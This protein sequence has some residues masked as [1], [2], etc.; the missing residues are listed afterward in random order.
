MLLV[1]VDFQNR[2]FAGFYLLIRYFRYLQYRIDRDK[3]RKLL[4][5]AEIYSKKPIKKERRR[6]GT[7]SSNSLKTQK[8][9]HRCDGFVL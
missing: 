3:Y 4:T 8:D 6:A 7:F 9:R 1:L 2:L 5:V